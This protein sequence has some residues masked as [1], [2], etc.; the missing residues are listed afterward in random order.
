MADGTSVGSMEEWLKEAEDRTD[1]CR[2]IFYQKAVK[3]EFKSAKEGRAVYYDVDMVIVE[4]PGESKLRPNRVVTDEDKARWPKSWEA[5]KKG[6]AQPV[7]GTPTEQ[8]AALTPGQVETFRAAGIRTVEDIARLPDSACQVLGPN[9][10]KLREAANRFIA[11]PPEA[12]KQMQ[13]QLANQQ[14]IIDELQA[15]LAQLS[16]TP[17]PPAAPTEE[18]RGPGRPRKAA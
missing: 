11:P 14:R 13:E 15:K 7:N 18:H 9:G 6:L 8:W 17:A 4:I 3:D 12:Q 1:R 16:S 5:Y 10:F 2:P